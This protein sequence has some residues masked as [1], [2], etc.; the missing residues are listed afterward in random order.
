MGKRRVWEIADQT[1]TATDQNKI[2]SYY[3]D[4]ISH[5][6][7]NHKAYNELHVFFCLSYFSMFYGFS[8]NKY[9]SFQIQDNI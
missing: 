7:S 9:Y 6:L 4:S 5:N 2:I 1:F 3:Q 8:A